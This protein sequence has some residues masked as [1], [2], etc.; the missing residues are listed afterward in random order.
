MTIN[1]WV[2]L[3]SALLTPTIAIGGAV[4]A[5]LQWKTNEKKRKNDLF[6]RRYD[7]YKNVERMWVSTGSAEE[8]SQDG[9]DVETLVP[10]ATASAVTQNRP[11]T[12]TSKPANDR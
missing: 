11:M 12:V 9:L 8:T 10:I 2:E 4:I 7:F 1:E 6:D 3:S 5:F